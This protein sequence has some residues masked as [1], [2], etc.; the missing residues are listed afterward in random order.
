MK[1]SY[2]RDNDHE[3]YQ[4]YKIKKFEEKFDEKHNVSPKKHDMAKK[5]KDTILHRKN[6][7]EYHQK[8]KGSGKRGFA[9]FED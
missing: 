4:D 8:M 5:M 7:P 1:A 3:R 6:S 2:H 9:R